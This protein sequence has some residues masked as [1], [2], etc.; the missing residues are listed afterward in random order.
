MEESRE[1]MLQQF[2]ETRGLPTITSSIP[3]FAATANSHVPAMGH[4]NRPPSSVMHTGMGGNFPLQRGTH[5]NK[6]SVVIMDSGCGPN[7]MV[8]ECFLPAIS[9]AKATTLDITT[10][11][12]DVQ[13]QATSGDVNVLVQSAS[14]RDVLIHFKSAIVGGRGKGNGLVCM[15]ELILQGWHVDHTPSKAFLYTPDKTEVIVLPNINGMYTFGPMFAVASLM[16]PS[17][18]DDPPMRGQLEDKNLKCAFLPGHGTSSFQGAASVSKPPALVGILRSTSKAAPASGSRVSIS[19]IEMQGKLHRTRTQSEID[20]RKR[21]EYL[22]WGAPLVPSDY[23]ELSGYDSAQA[24]TQ[25]GDKWRENMS[26]LLNP[27]TSIGSDR[28]DRQ[29]FAFTGPPDTTP[30]E[31]RGMLRNNPLYTPPEGDFG[32]E[33]EDIDDDTSDSG[34]STRKGSKAYRKGMVEP[35]KLKVHLDR[36]DEIHQSQGHP[37]QA[38]MKLIIEAMLPE[39]NPPPVRLLHEWS[40]FRKCSSCVNANMRR[41]DQK[42]THPPTSKLGKS[43]GTHLAF[44]GTGAFFTPSQDG[45]TEAVLITCE[46]SR[47]RWCFANVIKTA[48]VIVKI[49]KDFQAHSPVQIRSIRADNEFMHAALKDHCT[50]HNIKLTSCAAHTHQQN[51]FA[52]STVK[53]VKDTS[54]VNE[55][56]AKTGRKLRAK[57][58]KYACVQLNKT[59]T[60]TDPSGKNRSPMEIWPDAP[61]SHNTQILHRWGQLVY[62]HVGKKTYDPNTAPRSRPGIFVGFSENTSGCLIYHFDTD[63]IMT[64][65]YVDAIPNVFPCRQQQMLGEHPDTPTDG[66]WREW[67]NHHPEEV[68]DAQFAEYVIGKQLQV[69]LPQEMYPT[70]PGRWQAVAVS[71]SRRG[72]SKTLCIRLVMYR[73]NGSVKDLT[74]GDRSFLKPVTPSGHLLFKLESYIDLPVTALSQDLPAEVINTHS[75]RELLT[76]T[77]PHALTMSTMAAHNVQLCGHHATRSV[78]REFDEDVSDDEDIQDE[79]LR[80]PVPAMSAA[81][82]KRQRQKASKPKGNFLMLPARVV[83]G[84]RNTSAAWRHSKSHRSRPATAMY[85]GPTTFESPDVVISVRQEGQLGFEPANINQARAHSTWPHWRDAIVKETN[86]LLSKGTW[87]P[88]RKS[89]VPDGVRIMMSQFVFKDKP[90]TGA[91]ARLVVRGDQQTPKPL[92]EDTYAP[93][94]SASEVRALISVSTREHLPLHQIDMTQAFTQS[95]DLDPSVPLYI[96]PPQGVQVDS[97]IVWK[98]VK[99]LYGLCV[100]PKAWSDTLKVFI[101]SYGFVNTNSSDTFFTYTSPEGEAIQLVFHVPGRP[102]VQFHQ[103][104]AWCS[105]QACSAFSL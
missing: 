48:D 35:L 9:N 38:R 63:R 5:V 1:R 91:K 13:I 16:A 25:F 20:A 58:L 36:I 65:P 22:T 3:N 75:L 31:M 32:D 68:P 61:F 40:F 8:P 57:S 78:I 28:Q 54:R 74:P 27:K 81:A 80:D 62:G 101:K 56:H 6:D 73:Y 90:F 55:L 2:M 53:L 100:A 69:V 34:K 104:R 99:P 70:Y 24:V 4:V 46:H 66:V 60:R 83:G 95:D 23:F 79:D 43:N 59:P 93:C 19:V 29:E 89:D 26:L 21:D 98:L 88:V 39:E 96:Y 82:T 37:G 102:S 44:D 33:E 92:M 105:F 41:P 76:M 71:S 45:E 85:A 64:Y 77:F 7:T 84:L 14:G 42:K 87:V 97:G 49:V 86:G 17:E 15:H 103:R 10:A 94:P 72:D 52:E 11:T 18:T 30:I 50:E 47:M 12:G 67:Y 51:P